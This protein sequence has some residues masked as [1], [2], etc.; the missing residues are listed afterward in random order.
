LQDITSEDKK[1]LLYARAFMAEME[2]L[3]KEE[4][5]K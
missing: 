2:K 1:M 5:K 3:A 4:A